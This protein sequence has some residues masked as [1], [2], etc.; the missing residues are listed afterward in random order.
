MAGK[1]EEKELQKLNIFAY[2]CEQDVF[3][4]KI[5]T[6]KIYESINFDSLI[7]GPKEKLTLLPNTYSEK[8]EHKAGHN[9]LISETAVM[10]PGGKIRRC[11]IGPGCR[12]GKNVELFNSILLE[13]V[14]LK[15]NCKI[16]ESVLGAGT[17]VGENAQIKSTYSESGCRVADSLK[18]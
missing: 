9:I 16:T 1:H 10:G 8:M 7:R 2:F 3:I 14:E 13:N 12:I 4:K 11:L 6:K 18:L 15:D 17:S 5:S